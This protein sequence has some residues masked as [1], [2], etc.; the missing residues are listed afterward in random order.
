MLSYKAMTELMPADY[1][2]VLSNIKKSGDRAK[3]NRLARRNTEDSE[4]LIVGNNS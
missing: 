3:R 2:K 4:I 1:Q